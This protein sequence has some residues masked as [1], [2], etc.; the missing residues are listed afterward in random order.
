MASSALPSQI[1]A[2]MATQGSTYPREQL[3]EMIGAPDWVAGITGVPWA[4]PPPLSVLRSLPATLGLERPVR[5]ERVAEIL[6]FG[7]AGRI[8]HYARAVRASISHGRRW[9]MPMKLNIIQLS[10]SNGLPLPPS[11]L[12]A[13]F[14]MVPAQVRVRSHGSSLIVGADGPEGCKAP[15]PLTSG[16]LASATTSCAFMPCQFT[17]SCTPIAIASLLPLSTQADCGVLSLARPTDV[18][19]RW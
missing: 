13:G 12:I 11:K 5:V 7:A 19:R 1:E 10:T 9:P 17:L 14:D 4:Q 18:S 2:A 15:F 3:I 8:S 6:P 16:C